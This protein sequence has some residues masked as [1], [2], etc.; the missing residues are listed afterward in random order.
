[1]GTTF[2]NN[3]TL[4]PLGKPTCLISALTD[5]RKFYAIDQCH[6]VINRL[7]VRVKCT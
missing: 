7:G 2:K 6:H 5:N 4:V 3:L 1:V